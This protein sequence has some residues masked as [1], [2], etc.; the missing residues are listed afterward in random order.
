VQ[1][2][3]AFADLDLEIISCFPTDASTSAAEPGVN[4]DLATWRRRQTLGMSEPLA[5]NV[6][7]SVLASVDQREQV[8]RILRERGTKA[9]P[10]ASAAQ[11]TAGIATLLIESSASLPSEVRWVAPAEL[12]RAPARERALWSLRAA[13]LAGDLPGWSYVPSSV[14]LQGETEPAYLYTSGDVASVKPRV[15][16]LRVA[17]EQSARAPLDPDT[18]RREFELR[19]ERLRFAQAQLSSELFQLRGLHRG[20]LLEFEQLE[21]ELEALTPEAISALDPSAGRY[22]VVGPAA[23]W[24]ETLQSLGNFEILSAPHSDALAAP[25]ATELERLWGAIGGLAAW[26]GLEALR[27]QSQMNVEGSTRSQGIEQWIDFVHERFVLA[28]AIGTQ[29]TMVVVTASRAWALGGI[30]KPELSVEQATRLRMRQER[31]LFALLRRLAQPELGGLRVQQIEERLLITDAGR[32]FCWLELDAKAMPRRLGYRLEG[33]TEE[34]LYQFEDW[35][36]DGPLPY[37]RRTLQLDRNA[38]VELRSFE[39]G[40]LPNPQIWE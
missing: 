1:G 17:L 19:A 34:S 23:A 15:A 38:V 8:E 31:T 32:A 35:N 26:R 7:L 25:T 11:S 30:D 37:P 36:F 5:G 9:R 24:R 14:N 21:R 33:E 6:S 18:A 13:R 39:P 16:A 40:A 12:R 10:K 27:M 2:F 20:A 3:E 4:F 28:Q 29:E 22:G